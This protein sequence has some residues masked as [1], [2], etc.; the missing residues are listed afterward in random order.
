MADN[1]NNYT[2]AMPNEAMCVHSYR[3]DVGVEPYCVKC[4]AKEAD[5]IVPPETGLD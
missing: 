4:G 2:P 3:Y 1:P 5:E